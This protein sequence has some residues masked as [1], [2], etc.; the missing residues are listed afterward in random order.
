MLV[1]LGIPCAIIRPT[2]VFGDGDLLLN[3][4]AS[5]LRRLPVFPVYGM[6][7]IRSSP[8]TSKILR[9]RRWRPAHRA[10]APWPTLPNQTRSPSGHCLACWPPRWASEGGSYTRLP[11]WVSP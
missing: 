10:R 2:L 3:N 6:A 8:S 7:T 1:G 11:A 9:P 5:A 4:M